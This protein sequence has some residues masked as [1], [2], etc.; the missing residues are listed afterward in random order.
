MNCLEFRR[1][2]TIDPLAN[3]AELMTHEAECPGCASY[4]REMRAQEFAL[5][6]ALKDITPPAGLAERV[7]LAAHYEQ[8]AGHRRRWWYGAAASLLLMVGVSMVNVFHNAHQRAQQDLAQSVLR[9][10]A[11]EA[12]HLHEVSAVSRGRL[13]WVFQRFGARLVEDIGRVN[14][15][16]ECLMRHRNGVHLVL[17]GRLGPVT[18]FFMPGEITDGAVPIDSAQMTGR[19]V[20]T[21]W[22]SIAVV[23]EIGE[24]LDGLGER[25]AGAVEW[26]STA[27]T[28]TPVIRQRG[29]AGRFVARQQKDG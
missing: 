11:D 5:R 6:A 17:P 20:P 21:A 3:D 28:G 14:F 26:P 4:A 1:R 24:E 15:A 8:Q 25:L 9:H 23:G 18:V 2:T 16:A 12:H 10:I 27:V 19:I 22:G 7:V 29:V 13:H